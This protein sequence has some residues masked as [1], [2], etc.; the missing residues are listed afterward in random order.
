MK[1]LLLIVIAVLGLLACTGKND[2]KDPSNNSATISCD[3]DTI[4]VSESGGKFTVTVSSKAEWSATADNSWVS[5]SPNSGHGDAFVTINVAAGK[6]DKAHVLFS[7]GE[8]SATLVVYRENISCDPIVKEVS[9]YGEEFSVTIESHSSWSASSNMP[10]VTVFPDSGYGDTEVHIKVARNNQKEACVTFSSPTSTATLTIRCEEQGG[11]LPGKFSVNPI[12]QVQFSQG[13]LQYQARTQTWRFA[14]NQYDMIGSDNAYIYAFY[15][16]WIDLFG[17]GTGNNPT[18]SSMDYNDYS[19]FVDWGTNAISNGGNQTNLW[20]TLTKD[21]WVYLFYTRANAAN[22]F[23]LGSVNGANG[24]II[25]P[26]NWSTPQGA[27]FTP[28]T[29]KGLADTGYDYYESN[30]GHFTDNT[31]SVEQWSKMESAGAVFLPAAGSR[32]DGTGVHDVGSYGRYWSST[33]YGEGD[34]YY[35]VF[36]SFYFNPQYYYNRYF[37]QSV[38]LVKDVE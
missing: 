21:E 8:S 27:S 36:D 6:K 1:K 18:N 24:T 10:W 29:S 34:A 3:I 32:G 17:W 2:P 13:N 26:D 16:G 5:I 9:S 14:E 23:G 7:N 35:L 15:S 11:L 25:L 33:P 31:Y 4:V 28:S 12:K 37:G 30:A 19:T 38:R 20:R 22:R